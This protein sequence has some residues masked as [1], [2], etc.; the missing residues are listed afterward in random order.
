LTWDF[1]A[2]HPDFHSSSAHLDATRPG[3]YRTPSSVSRRQ[4]PR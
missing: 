3:P 1:M 2:H 4:P